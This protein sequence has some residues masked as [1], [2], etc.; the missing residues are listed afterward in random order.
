[1][2]YRDLVEDGHI[3]GLLVH[4]DWW[5]PRHPQ[6]IP[7][8]VDDAQALYRPAPELSAPTGEGD[9]EADVTSPLVPDELYQ[10]N[11]TLAKTLTGTETSIP[12]NE[13]TLATAGDPLYI[14]QDDLSWIRVIVAVD[15]ESPSYSIPI[16][17][18]PVITDSASPGNVVYVTPLGTGLLK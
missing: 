11:A 13:A 6:E 2:L 17:A 1:M 5:E 4:P 15:V 18:S 3:K 8:P 9:P 16:V 12:V 7:V 10:S 14:Q